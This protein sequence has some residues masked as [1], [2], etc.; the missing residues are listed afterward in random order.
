MYKIVSFRYES[1]IQK[2]L[3]ANFF[4]PPPQSQIRSYGLGSRLTSMHGVRRLDNGAII[5]CQKNCKHC[6][7]LFLSFPYVNTKYYASILMQ[8]ISANELY[9]VIAFLD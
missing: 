4:L 5:V 1:V 6:P 7:I 8:S 2:N 9:L 3:R